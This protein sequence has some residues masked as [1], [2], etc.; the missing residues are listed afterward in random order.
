[1]KK[2]DTKSEVKI[3]TFYNEDDVQKRNAL[4]DL[5]EQ[6]PIPKEELFN[7][8]GL[9]VDRRNL[10]RFLYMNELYQKI[11]TIHGSIVEFGVRYGQNIALL[12]SL[13][14]IYEPFNHNR[15][16]IGFDTWEGFT[17]VDSS[18]D[19]ENWDSG[20]F[21]VP[22]NYELYLEKVINIHEQMAPIPN[23]KKHTLVKGDAITTID[24][25]LTKHQES[26]ISFVYFDF[27]LYKPTKECLEKILPYLSRGAVIAFDEIN[28]HEF[29]GETKAFREVLGTNNFKV[30]HSIYRANAGYIVYE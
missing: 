6:T 2:I 3:N 29:P 25:Y 15:K 17:S 23:I 1:M 16:I 4:Q 24:E 18:K 9:F 7:N 14:G 28:V 19:T 11:L 30:H 12:T 20:D 10:S 26:I 13:R 8:M 22:Q 27:D 21:G 5:F